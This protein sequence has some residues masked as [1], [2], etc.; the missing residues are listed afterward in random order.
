MMRWISKTLN[1]PGMRG[2][3]SS[4]RGDWVKLKQEGKSD[5]ALL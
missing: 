1:Q 4:W 5:A 3:L 2:R